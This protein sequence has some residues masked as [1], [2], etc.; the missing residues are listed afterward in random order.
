MSCMHK[1]K[2]QNFDEKMIKNLLKECW[3]KQ[4][5]SLWT[6]KN[7]ARGQCGVTALVIQ[8]CFGGEILKTLVDDRNH[9]YNNIDGLKYD[10]TA[11]QFQSPPNYSDFPSSREEAFSNTNQNQYSYLLFRFRQELEYLDGIEPISL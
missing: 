6:A 2:P 8:D 7:P 11:D 1:A 3:S 9:F 5:S 10:F 4:S